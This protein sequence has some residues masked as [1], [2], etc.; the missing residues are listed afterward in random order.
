MES[1]LDNIINQYGN[2]VRRF[3]DVLQKEKDEYIRDSA[4]QRFE[5]T[6]EL[7]WKTMK[8]YLAE[9]GN[10]VYSPRDAIKSV[11]Q[12][13]LIPDNQL[14]LNILKTRNMTA[15]VYNESMAENVYAQ[16]ADYV[17]LF[18]DLLTELSK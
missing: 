17:P 8:A 16:L 12:L 2:A 15:H 18:Q 5:F 6:F 9:K 4:I 7:A 14:W 11:F 1:K 3:D 13:G 10:T